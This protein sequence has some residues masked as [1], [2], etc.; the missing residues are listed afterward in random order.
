MSEE[1]PMNTGAPLCAHRSRTGSATMVSQRPRVGS[2]S[3]P[4]SGI[5]ARTSSASSVAEVEIVGP[6]RVHEGSTGSVIDRAFTLLGSFD[7]MNETLSLSDLARRADLPV[8]TALRLIRRLVALG[9]LERHGRKYMLGLRLWEIASVSRSLKLRDMAMPVMGDLVAATQQHVLL[10]VLAGTDALLVERLSGRSAIP[11]LYRV[12]GRMPL[13]STASGLVLLAHMD[14]DDQERILRQPLMH[15]PE[16][17]RVDPA[18]LRRTLAEVRR[19]GVI[20]L[21]RGEPTPLVAVAAPIRG[22]SDDVVAALSVVMQA[23]SFNP[24]RVGP[25]VV[26]GARAISR[27][28]GSPRAAMLPDPAGGG[29]PRPAGPTVTHVGSIAMTQPQARESR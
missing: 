5:S 9:V 18:A 17:I 21:R 14:T 16:Q 24:A 27:G 10:A 26:A 2:P 1:A 4:L 12:G 22:E 19:I 29:S 8:S 20:T 13:H 28:L 7:P 23:G 15:V 3:V 6:H 25:A 11:V